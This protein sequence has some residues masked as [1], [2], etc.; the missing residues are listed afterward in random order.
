MYISWN[1]IA[2]PCQVTR[3]K[4]A[5]FQLTQNPGWGR[6]LA[7]TW[8]DLGGARE[9]PQGWRASVVLLRM[10]QGGVDLRSTPPRVRQAGRGGGASPRQDGVTQALAAARERFPWRAHPPAVSLGTLCLWP[11]GHYLRERRRA[12]Q[13]YSVTRIMSMIEEEEGQTQISVSDLQAREF[14][15]SGNCILNSLMLLITGGSITT[16][17]TSTTTTSIAPLL[18]QL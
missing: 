2:S 13:S 3:N 18:L 15:I 4:G 9:P 16:D 12:G 14:N 8:V 10:G 5:A 11:K 17:I 7:L 1:G 6:A